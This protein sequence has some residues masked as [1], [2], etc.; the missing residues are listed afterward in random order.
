MHIDKCLLM[1]G[2][3]SPMTEKTISRR[4]A[5][6][7]GDRRML[8][9]AAQLAASGHAVTVC[10]H[11]SA[12]MDTSAG[13]R[14]K[15]SFS[16]AVTG[17]DALVLPLPATRDGLTVW[18]PSEPTQAP[19]LAEIAEQMRRTP[20][21]RLFGGRLPVGFAETL[22]V[23]P[24]RVTDYYEDEALTLR[25]AY[26]TAEGALAT[27]MAVTDGCVRGSTVA[28]I[29]YGRIGKLLT[30]LLLAMGAEV[31]VCARRQDVL[32]WAQTD[33][34]HPLRIG[35]P[36]RPGGGMFP[37]CYGHS[38][39]FNTVPARI[40]E[41]DLL[42]RME[43]GTHLIDLASAPFVTSDEAIREATEANDLHYVRAPSLPGTYA[44]RDAG[45]AIA[46]SIL[47]SW[48]NRCT[49][50]TVPKADPDHSTLASKGDDHP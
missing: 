41:L 2:K 11:G 30:R 25:N 50:S 14:A 8:F 42:L 49:P 10:G 31:T 12:P 38:V 6:L 15:T 3:E 17:A 36:T 37:L 1:F 16:T 47:R 22:R 23:D 43:R 4:I 45:A 18:C 13:V 26:L 46:D 33:G 29:G 32:L 44:P 39:I 7:G 9:A 48:A 19:A 5:V 34:A 24:S 27:A 21:L 40:L 35:D 20:G 28:V